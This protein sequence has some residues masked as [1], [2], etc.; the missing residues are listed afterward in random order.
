MP[1]LLT[2]DEVW[3]LLDLPKAIELAEAAFHEQ[4]QGQ[5]VPHAPYHIPVSLVRL[6]LGEGKCCRGWI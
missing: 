4:A 3:P 1:L 6:Y 5:V 2:R